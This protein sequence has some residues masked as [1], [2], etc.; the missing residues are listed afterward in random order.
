[1][2]ELVT[3]PVL[4]AFVALLSLIIGTVLLNRRPYR[5]IHTSEVASVPVAPPISMM[6]RVRHAI[7]SSQGD[8]PFV[9][10][11][12]NLISVGTEALTRTPRTGRRAKIV[13]VDRNRRGLWC[14]LA[15]EPAGATF[16][17]RSDQ[18]RSLAAARVS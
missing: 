9:L 18:L 10:A 16:M 15:D 7:R 14:K 1:M 12:P 13:V 5:G 8:V 6:A 4:T 17:R 3:F 2:P 11:S